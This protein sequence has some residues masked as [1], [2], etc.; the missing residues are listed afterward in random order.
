MLI[1]E[2]SKDVNA[3]TV[4]EALKMQAS[5]SAQP[6]PPKLRLPVEAQSR[7]SWA[8]SHPRIVLAD[9]GCLYVISCQDA[10]LSRFS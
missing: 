8:N 6:R 5:T 10:A 9:L 2:E 1:E 7:P 3:I 4:R